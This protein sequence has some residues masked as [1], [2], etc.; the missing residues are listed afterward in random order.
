M[1]SKSTD[2]TSRV[3]LSSRKTVVYVLCCVCVV[4]I[5]AVWL[6]S[7][8]A[9]FGFGGAHVSAPVAALQNAAMTMTRKSSV[10]LAKRGLSYVDG[11][12]TFFNQRI[13]GY[14]TI[15]ATVCGES[16]LTALGFAADKSVE[17]RLVQCSVASVVWAVINYTSHLVAAGKDKGGWTWDSGSGNSKRDYDE[18][19]GVLKASGYATGRHLAGSVYSVELSDKEWASA[20]LSKRDGASH[21]RDASHKEDASDK[22]LHVGKLLNVV[23]GGVE[24]M[25]YQMIV[26]HNDRTGSI[27]AEPGALRSAKETLAKCSGA[28]ECFQEGLVMRGKA[29]ATTAKKRSEA[30]G[31]W[32]SYN[33]WGYNGGN[34]HNWWQWDEF[35]R[36]ARAA[37]G[38]A[39]GNYVVKTQ[40][41]DNDA[42]CYAYVSK[43]CVAGGMLRMPGVDSAFVGEAYLYGYGGIDTTCHYL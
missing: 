21:K 26:S 27:F 40:N 32:A 19:M 4:S 37:L 25:G 23:G 7:W 10:A 24:H 20:G 8:L 16:M 41:C 6:S 29:S 34:I 17:G 35:S 1:G 18:H 39:R 30:D 5:L 28:G 12:I 33:D 36:A 13:Q 3:T 15:H 43:W 14:D 31:I 22:I 9:R 42:K 38:Q 2:P 11:L